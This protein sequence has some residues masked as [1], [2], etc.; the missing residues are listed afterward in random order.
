MPILADMDKRRPWVLKDVRF[1]RMLPLWWPLLAA[2]AVCVIPYRNPLDVAASSI[3]H[4]TRV[5]ENYMSAALATTAALGCPTALVSYHDWTSGDA[6]G[7]APAR[8]AAHAF[9]LWLRR[10]AR[11]HGAAPHPACS[12]T[13][14]S[15]SGDAHARHRLVPES[16][17]AVGALPLGAAARQ[18]GAAPPAAVHRRRER[19]SRD[20]YG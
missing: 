4:S 11:P 17:L 14:C 16:A 2:G 18:V 10:R 20:R 3:L 19:A 12:S 1:A 5:W 15:A 9:L 6:R 8:R 7:A 13:R